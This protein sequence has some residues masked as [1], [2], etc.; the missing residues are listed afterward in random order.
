MIQPIK[1]PSKSKLLIILLFPNL[2]GILLA[3][4]GVMDLSILDFNWTLY[5]I[6]LFCIFSIF[7]YLGMRS[8]FPKQRNLDL[9]T[10]NS[11]VKRFFPYIK[12]CIP[13]IV[14]NSL[15][16]LLGFYL[17]GYIGTVLSSERLGDMYATSQYIE[18]ISSGPFRIVNLFTLLTL[19]LSYLIAAWVIYYKDHIAPKKI[20]I[21]LLCCSTAPLVTVVSFGRQSTINYLAIIII[22]YWIRYNYRAK[23]Y[24]YWIPTIASILAVL[25]IVFSIGYFRN[26]A[27]SIGQY[28]DVERSLVFFFGRLSHPFLDILIKSQYSPLLFSIFSAIIYLSHSWIYMGSMLQIELPFSPLTYHMGTFRMALDSLIYFNSGY[29]VNLALKYSVYQVKSVM[30]MNNLESN[31]WYTALLTFKVE[32]G[33]YGLIFACI[34]YGFLFGYWFSTA[35]LSYWNFILGILSAHSILNFWMFSSLTFDYFQFYLFFGVLGLILF[36]VKRKKMLSLINKSGFYQ[37]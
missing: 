13:L 18:V 31:V 33:S 23:D 20:L 15:L 9:N 4:S 24:P 19:P 11:S 35:R 28:D 30:E 32:Y 37:A 8:G 3:F 7:V 21:V 12:F 26:N 25:C 22:A 27:N 17:S 2:L 1:L 10:K 6:F 29:P 36:K 14:I 16:Y 5:G 34:I